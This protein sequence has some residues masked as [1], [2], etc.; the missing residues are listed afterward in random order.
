MTAEPEAGPDPG[1]TVALPAD[2]AFLVQFRAGPAAPCA[3]RVEHLASGSAAR[4]GDWAGLR[5]FVDRVLGG[6][7]RPGGTQAGNHEQPP[8]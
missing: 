7:A 5:R 8:S 6:P 3:G 4:F 2:R 1:A